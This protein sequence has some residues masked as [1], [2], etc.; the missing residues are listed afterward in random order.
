M[1]IRIFYRWDDAE[2]DSGSHTRKVAL[3]GAPSGTIGIPERVLFLE[4]VNRPTLYLAAATLCGMIFV[5]CDRESPIA[6][7]P[8]PPPSP[9]PASELIERAHQA[10]ALSVGTPPPLSQESTRPEREAYLQSAEAALKA[11]LA[12]PDA[13]LDREPPTRVSRDTLEQVSELLAVELADAIDRDQP[14][15]VSRAIQA[16]YAYTDYWSSSGITVWVLASAM[17]E[18]LAMGV[19]SVASQ[20]DA[21]LIA[22]VSETLD[23]IS[24]NPPDPKPAIQATHQ[25]ILD[26]RAKLKGNTQVDALLKAYATSADG[27]PSLSE[28]LAQQIRAFAQRSGDAKLLREDVLLK[29]ADVAVSVLTTFLER[30]TKGEDVRIEKP[31]AEEHP[32]ALLFVLFFKP[33]VEMAPKL[34]ALRQEGIQ[35]LALTVRIIAAGIPTDLSSFEHLAISPVSNLPFGYK[36]E[37]D[38]FVLERPRRMNPPVA[39]DKEG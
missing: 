29:E 1:P 19:R 15:R 36:V 25:R 31:S 2:G 12:L 5:G 32:I 13:K 39:R 10:L 16:A 8:S 21:N 23:T 30:A 22:T 14:E 35:I 20:V 38:T 26:W 6:A 9:L 34:V 11:L 4:A 17:P 27:R 33:D 24:S 3:E 7:E 37:G 28:G 18:R